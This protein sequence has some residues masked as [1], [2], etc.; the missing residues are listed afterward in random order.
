MV[1]ARILNYVFFM[2]QFGN[3]CFWKAF[4]AFKIISKLTKRERAKVL[5]H[6]YSTINFHLEI[7]SEKHENGRSVDGGEMKRK[8]HVKCIVKTDCWYP[9]M[10][11]AFSTFLRNKFQSIF[12]C[13]IYGMAKHESNQLQHHHRRI[14]CV[15]MRENFVCSVSSS[16][17]HPKIC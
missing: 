8:E 9:K 15:A 13:E 12:A 10:L 1:Q 4:S 11:N 7:A 2:H 6:F 3:N 5:W 14:I 17:E 16:G